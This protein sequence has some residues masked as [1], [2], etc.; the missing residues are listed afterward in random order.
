MEAALVVRFANIRVHVRCWVG[1]TVLCF[2]VHV[3]H[4]GLRSRQQ[5]GEGERAR[6]PRHRS[7]NIGLGL[8]LRWLLA[9]LHV[10]GPLSVFHIVLYHTLWLSSHL[11]VLFCCALAD[12]STGER[13]TTTLGKSIFAAALDGT[14][15]ASCTGQ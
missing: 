15:S 4:E 1:I 14:Q 2:R 5:P 7:R 9:L 3:V 8:C 13:S 12:I 11:C 10:S 6:L